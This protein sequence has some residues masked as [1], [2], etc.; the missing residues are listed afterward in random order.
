MSWVIF[1]YF[2]SKSL[3]IRK[4]KKVTGY[5][6]KFQIIAINYFILKKQQS[7]FIQKQKI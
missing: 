4:Y 5:V 2:Y 6:I 3:F 1:K 7:G